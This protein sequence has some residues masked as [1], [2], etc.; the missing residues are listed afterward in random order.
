ML[1]S[2]LLQGYMCLA[3]HAYGVMYASLY[4]VTGLSVIYC[5]GVMYAWLY[6]V[7]G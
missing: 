1:C 7:T 5:Y 2:T 3:V 4:T 6:T